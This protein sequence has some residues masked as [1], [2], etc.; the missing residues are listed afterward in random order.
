MKRA[1][2]LDPASPV[3]HTALGY[4][5]AMSRDFDGAIREN[6]KAIEL[7]PDLLAP[8]FNLAEAYILN[9]QFPEALEECKRIET[10]DPLLAD[11]LRAFAYGLSGR[12]E[13]ALK[14][15]AD[16][17]HSR[18]KSRIMTYDI[19]ALYGAIGDKATAFEYLPKISNTR[20]MN[21][22]LKYDAKLDSLRTDKRF[23]DLLRE[24]ATDPSSAKSKT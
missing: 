18:D 16:I 15:V 14:A 12:R 11:F 3:S 13:L 17:E 9:R 20:F 22:M 21:A 8:Q 2:E 6:K 5:L 1:V 24:R 4:I 19:A 23:E 10:T 7:Q